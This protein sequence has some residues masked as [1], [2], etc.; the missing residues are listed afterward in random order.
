LQNGKVFKYF[1]EWNSSKTTINATQLLIRLY[2]DED[3]RFSVEY[4]NG[5]IKSAERP[6]FPETS[7]YVR[8]E[9]EELDNNKKQGSTMH[10]SRRSMDMNDMGSRHSQRSVISNHSSHMSVVGS[11]NPSVHSRSSKGFRGLQQAIEFSNKVNK[12][13]FSES[14]INKMMLDVAHSFDIRAT[15]FCVFYRVGFDL[16]ELTPSE[17]QRME[18]IQLYPYLKNGEIWKDI[19]LELE[20][21]NI[22]PTSDDDHWMETA[23]EESDE[24]LENAIYN[25]NLYFQE[26]QLKEQDD[27]ESY[28]AAIRLKNSIK[29]KTLSASKN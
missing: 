1:V 3:R 10:V 12:K 26:I 24:H 29:G 16:H 20:D 23:I 4:K 18:I 9:K 25:Q 17:K 13:T 8:K 15:I 21:Y 5:I 2:E 7:Y 28:Y 19:K 22:K 14:Y 27:L 11:Q 6:L